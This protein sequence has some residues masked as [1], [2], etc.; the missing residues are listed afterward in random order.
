MSSL[1][2]ALLLEQPLKAL[3]EYNVVD[4]P[5]TDPLRHRDSTT[6]KYF[7]NRSPAGLLIQGEL[8]PVSGT[9]TRQDELTTLIEDAA[10]LSI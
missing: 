10:I 6:V 5:G 7:N 1:L 9:S 4:V 3:V 8:R 2:D